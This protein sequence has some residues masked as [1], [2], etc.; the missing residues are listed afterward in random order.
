[1]DKE[2]GAKKGIPTL[3]L[4]AS[5]L[6]NAYVIVVFST[7]TGMLTGATNNFLLSLLD[8]PV[9]IIT[10]G[11]IGALFGFA[12]CKLFAYAAPRA[13]KKTLIVLGAGVVLIW[14]QEFLKPTIAMSGLIGVMVMGFVLLEKSE[15]AAHAISEKLS[16]IWVAAEI[17]LFVLVGAQVDITVA[18]DVGASGIVLI[19]I[20][21]IARSVGTWV[22]VYGAGFNVKEKLFCLVAYT[23]KATV[24]AAIGA[25]PLSMG[26]N[27]GEVILAV[28]VLS[29]L[30]T[31]PL[32]AIGIEVTGKRWLQ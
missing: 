1:M 31:A 14:L 28:A 11:G 8:V 3:I 7:L 21:L 9:S 22:S 15:V 17:I 23:P 4:A 6:D 19:T 26:V 13:T 20:G 25:I 5:S 32:G 27:G 29:I 12:F 10:G 2:L 30:V 18:W 24:Q 16:K